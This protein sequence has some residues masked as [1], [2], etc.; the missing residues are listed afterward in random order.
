MASAKA[1]ST[2]DRHEADLV[3]DV[4]VAHWAV[5]SAKDIEDRKAAH[6]SFKKAVRRLYE[7]V[8]IEPEEGPHIE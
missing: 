1:K 7:F 8:S 4:A 5:N 6:D 2:R 3:L